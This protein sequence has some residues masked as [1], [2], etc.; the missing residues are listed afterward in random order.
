[1]FFEQFQH[2]YYAGRSPDILIRYQPNV[3]LTDSDKPHGTSHGT[4]YEYDSHVPLVFFGAGIKASHRAE[5][6]KTM[7]ISPTLSKLI[8]VPA[9]STEDGHV[10]RG[11][12]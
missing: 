5:Q 12:R 3:L 10:L 1:P 9:P 6:V 2:N 7:D 8:A 11:L 4:P